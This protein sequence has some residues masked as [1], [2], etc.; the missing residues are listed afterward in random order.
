MFYNFHAVIFFDRV[1]FHP[2]AKKEW[3]LRYIVFR[4]AGFNAPAAPDTFVDMIP[5]P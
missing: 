5:I 2:G 3:L 4:F 1:A